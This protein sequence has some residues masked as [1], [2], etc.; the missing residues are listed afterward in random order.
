[1]FGPVL[2]SSSSVR[3]DL[4]IEEVTPLLVR[5]IQG[6]LGGTQYA[7]ILL[8]MDYTDR[9]VKN[10]QTNTTIQTFASMSVNRNAKFNVFCF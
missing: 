6:L 5:S 3:S 8:N 7:K 2:Y 10:Y 9:N 4:T 1:V